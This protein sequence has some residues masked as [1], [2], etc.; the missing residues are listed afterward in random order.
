MQG[1]RD[2]SSVQQGLVPYWKR[3]HRDWR[4]W[5]A[6]SL[7]IMGMIIYVMSEDLS[8]RPQGQPQQSHPGVIGK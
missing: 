5:V 8:V 2:G 1:G 7:M 6:V 3:A 4:V